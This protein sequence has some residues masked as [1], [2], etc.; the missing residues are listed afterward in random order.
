M[1]NGVNNVTEKKAKNENIKRV[2]LYFNIEN[3]IEAKMWQYLCEKRKKSVTIKR[4]LE[5]EIEGR[6][7]KSYKD[8][9]YDEDKKK[10]ESNNGKNEKLD[11]D[12]IDDDVIL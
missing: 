1:L 8:D 2:G 9:S 11:E 5:D 7:F 10:R 3:P 4:L 6:N 12:E